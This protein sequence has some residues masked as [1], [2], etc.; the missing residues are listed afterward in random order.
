[1]SQCF[2]KTKHLVERQR[3]PKKWRKKTVAIFFGD[4]F[5]LVTGRRSFFL[6]VFRISHLTSAWR[7]HFWLGRKG[8]PPS[9]QKKQQQQEM[10]GRKWRWEKRGTSCL[11][12]QKR[13]LL[14]RTCQLAELETIL[15]SAHSSTRERTQRT[16]HQSHEQLAFT[17]SSRHILNGSRKK[18][19]FSWWIVQNWKINLNRW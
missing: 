13:E 1:M 8:A 10:E 7:W 16:E 4:I 14:L 3:E 6:R 17:D 11:E 9:S 12:H 18:N 19:E 2:R 15:I 5:K